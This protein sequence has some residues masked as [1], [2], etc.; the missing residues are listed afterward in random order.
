MLQSQMST[1][2]KCIL[3]S[4]YLFFKKGAVSKPKQS[5]SFPIENFE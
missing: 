4:Y 5:Q 1:K 2:S 3:I